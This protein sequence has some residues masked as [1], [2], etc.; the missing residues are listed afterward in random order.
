[1]LLAEALADVFVGAHDGDVGA[2]AH[3]RLEQG[4]H[5]PLSS[6]D[7]LL[8]VGGVVVEPPPPVLIRLLRLVEIR[9]QDPEGA[10][11]DPAMAGAC[12]AP[13]QPAT[14][15]RRARECIRAPLRATQFELETQS[16]QEHRA[17]DCRLLPAAL[18]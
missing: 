8:V 17:H 13:L 16:E 10:A 3:G 6:R 1:M 14:Q 11:G 18:C 7:V 12:G 2:V 5:Q 15:E 4:V 9:G